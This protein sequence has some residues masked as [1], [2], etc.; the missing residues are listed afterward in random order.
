MIFAKAKITT[1][2]K[3]NQRLPNGRRYL[4]IYSF[5]LGNKHCALVVKYDSAIESFF[6]LYTFFEQ[7]NAIRF[8]RL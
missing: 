2:V 3:Q 7:F 8:L 1:T 6:L 4:F 5:P